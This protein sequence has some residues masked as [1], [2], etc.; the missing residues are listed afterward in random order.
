MNNKTE[1]SSYSKQKLARAYMS[2]YDALVAEYAAQ[3]M[4][5][6]RSWYCALKR[7]YEILSQEKTDTPN[8]ALDYLM[9]FYNTHREN[10]TKK[11]MLSPDAGKTISKNDDNKQNIGKTVESE[12]K[13]LDQAI[14]SETHGATTTTAHHKISHSFGQWLDYQPES[15]ITELE[16]DPRGFERLYKKYVTQ[17]NK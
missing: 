10:Q 8:P 1:L 11:M 15:S 16:N 12:M 4:T 6:G 3:N 5:L 13:K 2:L 7:I 9:T 17:H 14:K